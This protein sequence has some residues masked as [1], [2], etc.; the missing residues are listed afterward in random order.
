MFGQVARAAFLSFICLLV[1]G[2]SLEI[3]RLIVGP[4]YS[5]HG[6]FMLVVPMGAISWIASY[7]KEETDPA[8]EIVLIFVVIWFAIIFVNIASPLLLLL[9]FGGYIALYARPFLI[10]WNFV[11][12]RRPLELE[13]EKQATLS[14]KLDADSELAEAVLRHERARV[15]LND[16]ELALREAEEGRGGIRQ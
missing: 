9:L 4:T 5:E 7:G 16:A 2:G 11:F 8:I 12:V 1:S 10:G 13:A 6:L 3:V 14:H 15:A